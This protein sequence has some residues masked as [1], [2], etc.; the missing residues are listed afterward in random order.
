MSQSS[1]AEKLPVKLDEDKVLLD[2]NYLEYP[3]WFQDDAGAI[4]HQDGYVFRH[5]EHYVFRAGY[6]PPTHYDI[7]LLRQLIK[8]SQDSGWN[9][10]IEITRYKLVK[11]SG[12]K[13]AG[14]GKDYERLYDSLK[15]WLY[16]GVEFKNVF[17]D[18]TRLSNVE[19]GILQHWELDA[20]SNVLRIIFNH[21][22]IQ[23]YRDSNYYAAIN[24]EKTKYISSALEHRLHE[25]LT[26]NLSTDHQWKVSAKQL[27]TKIP[28]TIHKM[29]TF[30]K[31]I[32]T[33][34]N[35]LTQVTDLQAGMNVRKI[36][37]E[38]FFIFH[39]KKDVHELAVISHV[40]PL[41]K[42]NAEAYLLIDEIYTHLPEYRLASEQTWID[43]VR[44][45][46]I[47]DGRKP[48]DI[49]TVFRWGIR[50][51]FWSGIIINPTQ[52]RAKYDNV[53]MQSKM[54]LDP[55]TKT[56]S[57]LQPQATGQQ[58]LLFPQPLMEIEERLFTYFCLSRQKAHEAV[59][60]WDQKYIE[61]IMTVV[62]KKMKVAEADCRP[63]K[64]LG[65]YTWKALETDYRENLSQFDT[66]KKS[67]VKKR[68][69][70][71]QMKE[72]AEAESNP[73]E[74]KEATVNRL[75][76]YLNSLSEE[77]REREIRAFEEQVINTNALF[78][79][80]Y[81]ESGFNS[82]GIITE[83]LSFTKAK[84]ASPA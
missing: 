63:I 6:R 82:R 20:T 14:S 8:L 13:S 59:T 70:E 28:T 53:A 21:T 49:V 67:A 24:I 2:M 75:N 61:E 65:A 57:A 11:L 76:E 5:G 83:F 30:V 45:M 42:K 12:N 29:T 38:T 80:L 79:S 18:G 84:Q 15:R 55:S 33:A 39:R 48:E 81:K 40:E 35:H 9:A 74:S 62:E 16:S 44:A 60:R 52:F 31:R 46:I 4:T 1:R 47:T 17:Y 50:H 78:R 23:K 43:T 3:L 51:P 25:L 7:K 27:A 36:G 66:D 32:E 68:T 34:M 73:V 54:A 41:P 22:F 72:K 77:E 26:K 56:T 69:A 64:N 10:V 19:H 71:I 37:T 58:G